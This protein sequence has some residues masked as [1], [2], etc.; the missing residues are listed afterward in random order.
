MVK[1]AYR[2]NKNQYEEQEEDKNEPTNTRSKNFD[3]TTQVNEIKH[4]FRMYTSNV[5]VLTQSA[6]IDYS[7]D[8]NKEK[9]KMKNVEILVNS[10]ETCSSIKDKFIVGNVNSFFIR[11]TPT[12]DSDN[13]TILY[14]N[15]IIPYI[16]KQEDW[17]KTCDGKYVHESVVREVDTTFIKE[18]LGKY[19]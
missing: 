1:T 13:K 12:K 19:E 16:D 14:K 5:S 3:T 7:N 15:I 10:S 11:T 2:E 4:K 8:K 17:Y 9:S 18:K 6:T